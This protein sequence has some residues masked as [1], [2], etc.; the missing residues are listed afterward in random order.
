MSAGPIVLASTSE[1]RRRLLA[2]I[3]ASFRSV[4]PTC[5]EHAIHGAD[6]EE[7]ALLRAY[8]K[9]ESVRGPTAHPLVPRDAWVIGSDQVVDLD[10][11]ILG[12]PGTEERARAQLAAL[13]GRTHRLITSVVLLGPDVREHHVAMHLLTMRPLSATEIAEY[14]ALDRPE[15]C[16][17]SYRF[18]SRGAAL[19]STVLG[20]DRTAI[21][22]LPLRALSAML[23]RSRGA[24]MDGPRSPMSAPT[25]APVVN[26]QT[27]NVRSR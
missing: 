18:E 2:E 6:P 22:G 25:A 8:V 9:A 3:V 16:A 1:A 4:A 23:L 27:E 12:K 15:A 10:G 14:V 20:G 21:Q 26:G 19:M 17:G 11:A 24:P 7:T 5:D 13:A